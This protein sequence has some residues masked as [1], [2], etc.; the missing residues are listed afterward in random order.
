MAAQELSRC[1]KSADGFC[2]IGAA[3]TA[4]AIMLGAFGAHGLQDILDER[5]TAIYEK[6]VLYHFISALGILAGGICGR[7]GLITQQMLVWI[8]RLLTVGILI[9][10][11]SLY[12]LAI[13]QHRWLGMITPLGGICFII[14]WLLF[15]WG[16]WRSRAA[17]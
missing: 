3:L 17:A 5:G 11:G 10:S 1:N 8:V 16:C 14:G 12:L 15:A 13:T 2:A 6:A 4:A 7:I 9:F